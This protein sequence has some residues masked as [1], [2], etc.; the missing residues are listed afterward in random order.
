MV[1]L[2]A[3]KEKEKPSRYRKNGLCRGSNADC[4]SYCKFLDRKI[5]DKMSKQTLVLQL[6]A[7]GWGIS[8]IMQPQKWTSLKHTHNSIDDQSSSQSQSTGGV[9]IQGSRNWSRIYVKPVPSCNLAGPPQ[10][11]QCCHKA[12]VGGWESPKTLENPKSDC[13]GSLL[14]VQ[15]LWQGG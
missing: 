7:H 9:W 2:I 13:G 1:L 12:W 10:Q 15:D 5:K 3:A 6:T 4:S 14:G 11:L 8:P